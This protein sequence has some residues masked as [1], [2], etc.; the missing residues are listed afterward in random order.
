MIKP[1]LTLHR[2]ELFLAVLD[3]GGIGRAARL[4]HISQPAVSEHLKG[5]EAHFG[6]PLFERVGRGVRPTPVARY[7]EPFAREVVQLLRGAER[8]ARELAQL[9]AGSLNVGASSTPGTYLLPALLG[10]FRSRYPAVAL[11]LRIGNSRAIERWVA[12]AEVDLGVIGE[13]PLL[14]GLSA[15]PL[16]RD[17]LV[18]IV[19]RRHPLARR[20]RVS[21]HRLAHEPLIARE[22]GSST[23][24]VAERYL[25]ELEVALVPAMV[26]GSTEA[27]REAVAAGLGVA[28]VSA[29]AV[30]RADRR[31]VALRLTGA[32]WDRE[33]LVIER[34]A[35]TLSPAAG[36]FREYLLKRSVV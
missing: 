20:R 8:A 30:P 22:E 21:P 16:I 31:L 19:S 12:A 17:R 10:W 3:T 29:L 34:R 26:L 23:R 5:L 6:V 18:L 36:R 32:A 9:G 24:D 28:I 33:L 2:L 15:T 4:R 1:G 14:E 35:G 27:V 25:R 11:T 13:A 7:L